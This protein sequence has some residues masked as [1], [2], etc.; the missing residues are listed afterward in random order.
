MGTIV[1]IHD[2]SCLLITRRKGKSAHVLKERQGECV[3]STRAALAS[4][5][6]LGSE[7]SKKHH[8]VES[9][10]AFEAGHILLIS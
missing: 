8:Q 5:Q 4:G 3:A 2:D 10:M 6:D 9:R 1:R 7:V